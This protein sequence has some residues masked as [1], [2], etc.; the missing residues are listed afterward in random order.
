M[1]LSDIVVTDAIQA[2]LQARTR[3]EA[4][5]E[6]V[7]ALAQAGA[8]AKKNTS[9]IAK[10]IIAR[11]SQATTG[12]GKGIALPHAK[13]KE[14]KKPIATIGGAPDGLDFNSL[15]S[16]PVYSVILLLSSPDNPDEHLQAMETI[17]RHVQRDMFR[18]FLRQAETTDAVV[19]LIREADEMR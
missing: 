14:I 2:K 9:D 15:D 16:Q 11:E 17:F 12:I 13:I 7:A 1:K 4:I 19:D 10:A 8:I 6:L 5:Q 3:D 18:K